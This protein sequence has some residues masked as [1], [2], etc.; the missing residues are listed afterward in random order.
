MENKL[1]FRDVL[2]G[3]R[4]IQWT[5]GKRD[6]YYRL[7]W[8]GR[9][10]IPHREMAAAPATIYGCSTRHGFTG[11]GHGQAYERGGYLT[12]ASSVWGHGIN[13]VVGAFAQ[14]NNWAAVTVAAISLLNATTV[15]INWANGG[16]AGQP[17]M[18]GVTAYGFVFVWGATTTHY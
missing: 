5:Q 17:G 7:C 1:Y 18:T 11:G 3:R 13:N 9:V 12:Y 10:T 2:T 8:F 15:F 16:T 6:A 14:N 4:G